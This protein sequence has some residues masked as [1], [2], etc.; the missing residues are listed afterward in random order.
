[1][2]IYP[3]LEKFALEKNIWSRSL[4]LSPFLCLSHSLSH[5]QTHTFLALVGMHILM[6]CEHTNSLSR[7]PSLSLSLSRVHNNHVAV[8]DSGLRILMHCARSVSLSFS[9]SLSLS[10][11]LSHKHTRHTCSPYGQQ[12]A[13]TRALVLSLPPSLTHTHTYTLHTR[14]SC[15]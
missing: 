14:V 12:H 4:S 6:R 3:S 10:V 9:L 2:S 13:I 11:S 15:R 7:A 5:K 8:A 1:M